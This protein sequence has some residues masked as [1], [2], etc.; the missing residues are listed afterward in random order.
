VA[1]PDEPSGDG[2]QARAEPFRLPVGGLAGQ[3]E[4]LGPGQQLAGQLVLREALQ[5][6]VP[7]SGVLGVPGAVLTSRDTTG[8]DATGPAS[9]GCSRSTA[10]SARQSP[11]RATAAA[12]SATTLPVSWPL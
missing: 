4:Q 7:Q 2:E 9:P 3:G 10:M 5:R 11:P 6:Q 12:R 1:A 8:S